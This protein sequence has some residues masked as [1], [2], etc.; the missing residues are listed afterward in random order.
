MNWFEQLQNRFFPKPEPQLPEPDFRDQL[1]N[2]SKVF[3]MS[4]WIQLH[5]QTNGK[6]SPCCMSA[7]YDGNEIG[8]L[9]KD[10]DLLS[11]WNSEKMKQIRK[12]MLEGKQS[13]I[14][15]NCYKYEELGKPSER[16]SYNRDFLRFKDRISLTEPD[17]TLPVN[18]VPV[19][20]IRF[21]NKCNYKCRICNSEYSSLWFEEEL[22]LGK[23]KEGDPRQFKPIEDEEKFWKSFEGLL[24]SVERL[25]FAGGEPLF[26]EEH[27]R[28]LEH[29]ISIGKTDVNLTYNTN[30]S[31]LRF[32]RHQVT[33]LWKKFRQVDVW[34]SLD[35]MGGRGDYQ[36]KGQQWEQI[37]ENI[38]TIQRECPDLY[39]GVNVTV[40]VFNI[41]HIPEF[42]RHLTSTGLVQPERVNLYIL[43]YPKAFS[44]IHLPAALK[45]QVS[46]LY[47]QFE[48][49]YLQ[50]PDRYNHIRQHIQAVLAYMN[51]E[52]GNLQ[53]EF[54]RSIE[55]VDALRAENFVDTFPEL[56]LLWEAGA[57]QNFGSK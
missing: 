9:R 49:E 47:T 57:D 12:N 55:A 46:S 44:I 23:V 29:L 38:R 28:S 33:D 13:S 43:F 24:P 26:M 4:P 5:A 51:S 3:C 25:H 21:S 37:E 35:G 36:R 39:F 56:Q 52:E 14:C 41:F 31:V 8:D 42:Y 16:H 18:T 22:K 34:A 40:S 30:L 17:G 50:E 45:Q 11:S 10:P 32:K 53:K 6:V 15:G 20:D 1:L 54:R 7:V 19:I 48:T 2:D 27:Y